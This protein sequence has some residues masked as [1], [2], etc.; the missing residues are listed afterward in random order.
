V[1]QS[2]VDTHTGI[3]PKELLLLL[4]MMMMMMNPFVSGR[5][6]THRTVGFTHLTV[7]LL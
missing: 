6:S 3:E 7:L 2:A 1:V 4:L 5:L